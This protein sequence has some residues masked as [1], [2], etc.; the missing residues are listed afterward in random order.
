[1]QV[2]PLEEKYPAGHAVHP[3]YLSPASYVPA[4]HT[5]IE[6]EVAPLVTEVAYP[7]GHGVQVV[8]PVPS[9]YLLVHMVHLV[10]PVPE[11]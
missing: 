7:S 5:H 6:K 8:F 9:A 2:P 10:F 4:L 1:M 3:A 11:A